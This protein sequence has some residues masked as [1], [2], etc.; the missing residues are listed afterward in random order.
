MSKSKAKQA[1]LFL[2]LTRLA[3]VSAN[4]ALT[5]LSAALLFCLRPMECAIAAAYIANVGMQ[6]A[7]EAPHVAENYFYTT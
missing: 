1:K 6:S 4:P 5:A 3:V 7:Y 2:D